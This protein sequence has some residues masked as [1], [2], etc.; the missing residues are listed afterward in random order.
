M[1]ITQMVNNKSTH[2]E[3]TIRK[4]LSGWRSFMLSMV[5]RSILI[6][7]TK[8]AIPSYYM[9]IESSPSKVSDR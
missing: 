7:A 6:K 4:K 5:G 3:K 9:Q 1:D 8:E 2:L